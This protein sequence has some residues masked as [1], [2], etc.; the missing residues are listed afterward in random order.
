MFTLKNI[1][2]ELF[3]HLVFFQCYKYDMVQMEKAGRKQKRFVGQ[4]KVAKR[5]K[6]RQNSDERTYLTFPTW[7][8]AEPRTLL[9]KWTFFSLSSFLPFALAHNKLRGRLALLLLRFSLLLTLHRPFDP[10][11][12]RAQQTLNFLTSGPTCRRQFTSSEARAERGGIIYL[13]TLRFG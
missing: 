7:R 8:T 9:G 12:P 11:P 3:K 6:T 13:S 5:V 10:F 1:Y 4:E 2:L